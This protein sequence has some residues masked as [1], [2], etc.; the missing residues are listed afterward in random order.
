MKK[1]KFDT[2]KLA[3]IRK[4]Y[5]INKCINE[6]IKDL[7]HFEFENI[8]YQLMDEIVDLQILN[9]IGAK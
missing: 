2:I 9:K 5:N 4:N 3:V 6:M 1:V 8:K 7:P